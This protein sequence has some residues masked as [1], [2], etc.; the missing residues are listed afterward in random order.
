MALPSH[1]ITIVL[2]PFPCDDLI[3]SYYHWSGLILKVTDSAWVEVT[4]I[5]ALPFCIDIT[6]GANLV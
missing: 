3:L 4:M 1:N 2:E 6:I 5:A